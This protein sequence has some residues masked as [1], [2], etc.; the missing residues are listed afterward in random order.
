M[1]I[2]L[3]ITALLLIPAAARPAVKAS[4]ALVL[5]PGTGRAVFADDADTPRQPASTTKLMTALIA[6]ERLNPEGLL[7]VSARAASMPRTKADLRA[8]ASYRVRDLLGALLVGSSNDAAV[9][10][11][12]GVAG[13]ESRFAALMTARA[14]EIGCRDTRFANASGLTH[15][16][17]RT[18]CRDLLT[19]YA[20][21]RRSPRLMAVLKSPSFAIRHPSGGRTVMHNHNKLLGDYESAPIGKTGYTRAARHCFAGSFV[22]DGREYYVACM[23]SPRLWDDLRALTAGRASALPAPSGDADAAWGDARTRV[24]QRALVKLGY[25]PGPVDGI[26]GAKTRDAL[27]RFQAARGLLADGLPR[28]ASRAALERD[29]GFDIP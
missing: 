7:S 12:E 4:C 10:L 3:L 29:S 23:G 11:A 14:Q 28:A 15:P 25:K 22:R 6:S 5:D 13:S 2:R 21:V 27:R 19:I 9:V 18:T 17:Q 26:A 1:R 16:V 8:G 24:V 20:E